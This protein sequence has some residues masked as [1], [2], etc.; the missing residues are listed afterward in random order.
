MSYFLIVKIE[1]ITVCCN[2][3]TMQ[4]M[5]HVLIVFRKEYCSLQR[6]DN[7]AYESSTHRYFKKDIVRCNEET[8]QALS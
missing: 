3:E 2:E 4:P 7:K 5:S 1:I 6:R 8:M